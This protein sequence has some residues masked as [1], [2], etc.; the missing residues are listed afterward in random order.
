MTP[1][2][3]FL[4][5]QLIEIPEGAIL[6][7]GATSLR[8]V[9]RSILE[10]VS[11]LMATAESGRVSREDLV[12]RFAAPDRPVI[13]RLLDQLIAA[14]FISTDMDSASVTDGP[15]DIFYWDM[16]ADPR[17]TGKDLAARS[18]AIAGINHLT[19][20]IGQLLCE[21]AIGTVAFLDDPVLRN[22][23]FF[24]ADGSLAS[25]SWMSDSFA[26]M[27][28][29]I[30]SS[31]WRND[32]ARR[33]DLLIAATEFGGA[34]LLRAWNGFCVDAS[35][36]FLPVVKA[37]SWATIGPWVSPGETP[38]F[39]CLR[40]RENAAHEDPATRRLPEGYAHLAQDASGRHP[41]M[42]ASVAGQVALEV[43]RV[44]ALRDPNAI[45]RVLS[46]DFASGTTE[47]RPL[48]RMPRCPVCASGRSGGA[49]AIGDND[50]FSAA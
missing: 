40:G 45:G 38:C 13:E 35:I 23:D 2:L 31:Q 37:S 33:P 10:A 12:D 26:P 1:G 15:L 39:E 16:G 14:R 8:L 49:V 34:T 41:A 36:D 30:A 46:V 21:M 25:A 3:R 7:R 29:P 18:V 27:P 20:A 22:L 48:L 44:F 47:S 4:P 43:T 17:R 11:F 24:A 6:V 42:T 28:P 50:R 32:T 9:G 5:A 19:R